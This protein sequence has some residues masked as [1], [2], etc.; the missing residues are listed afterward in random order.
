MIL[1]FAYLEEP[2]QGPPPPSLAPSLQGRWRPL[3]P[4]HCMVRLE[5]LFPSV[6]P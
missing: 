6:E 3:Y 1:R 4:S 5:L 2:L